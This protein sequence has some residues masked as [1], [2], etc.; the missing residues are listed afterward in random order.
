MDSE[1][2]F[3]LCTSKDGDEPGD[4]LKSSKYTRICLGDVPS[5]PCEANMC[6]NGKETS[7]AFSIN[8][9]KIYPGII[10]AGQVELTEKDEIKINI[11]I[12]EKV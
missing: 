12:S 7:T 10:I 1:K 11:R 6:Y 4:S 3:G 5:C 2:S 9:G 8:P